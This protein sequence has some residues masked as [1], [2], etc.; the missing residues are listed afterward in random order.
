MSDMT[1]E[2]TAGASVWERDLYAH[3]TNHLESERDLLERY[4]ALAESTPSE[5]LRYLVNLLIQD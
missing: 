2:S 3:L 4:S 1:D 5:A